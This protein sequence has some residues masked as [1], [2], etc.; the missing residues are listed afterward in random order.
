M[1][2]SQD[3]TPP[4]ADPAI[5]R[6]DII[7]DGFEAEWLAGRRPHFQ[8]F[9]SA[10]AEQDRPN[11]FDELVAMDIEYRRNAGETPTYEDYA[12][13]FP[14]Y[15]VAIRRAIQSPSE[16]MHGHA[17]QETWRGYHAIT[18]LGK[19]TSGAIYRARRGKQLVAIRELAPELVDNNEAFTRFQSELQKV[20]KLHHP[21]LV[22]AIE[23][24][25]DR[26]R[27]FVVSEYV[28]G[29]DFATLV[30]R[31]GLVPAAEACEL[32]SQA[33]TGLGVAH[34][35]GYVHGNLKPDKLI[36]AGQ[37]GE[38]P[39]VKILGLG[40]AS[41]SKRKSAMQADMAQFQFSAPEVR[42]SRESVDTRADIYALGACLQILLYGKAAADNENL[43][44]FDQE[45]IGLT[46]EST[47]QRQVDLPAGLAEIVDR[48]L[49]E[50]P[51]ARIA[52]TQDVVN[53]L[54][55]FAE[56]ADLE[57]LAT[58]ANSP[59]LFGG[60]VKSHTGA[61]SQSSGDEVEPKPMPVE[62]PGYEM[63]ELLGR[64]GM[65]VVFRARQVE[66]DRDVAVKLVLSGQL[67]SEEQRMRLRLEAEAVASLQHP[68]IVQVYDAGDFNSQPFL[69][70]EFVPGESLD[71]HMEKSA[72][73][74]REAAALI[75]TLSRGIH[76]AHLRGIV[77]RDLKPAN[78]LMT[79]A[80]IPK[81]T[82]FG[83]AKRLSDDMSR[84]RSGMLLGTPRY[85]A[86]EQAAGG[87][88]RVGPAADIY[89]LGAILYQLLTRQ[90]VFDAE[91]L[92]ELLEAIKNA[93]PTPLRKLRQDVPRD[94]ETIC[95]KC[96]AKETSHRYES[97]EHLAEDLQRYRTSRPILARHVGTFERTLLWARR[98]PVIAALCSAVL[99]LGL[100]TLIG[101]GWYH[102]QLLRERDRAERR[103]QLASH[104]VGQIMD[105]VGEDRLII[106]PGVEQ[107][108]QELLEK[109]LTIC[110][111]LTEENRTDIAARRR[112]GFAHRRTGDVQRLLGDYQAAEASYGQAIG[113]LSVLV[114]EHPRDDESN[115][116]LAAAHNFAG[117]LYRTTGRGD[118]ARVAYEEARQIQQ[119]LT[120]RSNNADVVAELARTLYNLGLV[121]KNANQ[122]DAAMQRLLNA[123]G[124]LES[125]T[126]APDAPAGH[127]QHLARVNLNRGSVLRLLKR[128]DEAAAAFEEAIREFESLANSRPRFTEYR[129][130]LAVA[131][132][133]HGN[134]LGLKDQTLATSQLGRSREML[135]QLAREYPRVPVYQQ[136]L[137]NACNGLA[138]VLAAQGHL[139]QASTAW[140]EATQSLE[141][142]HTMGKSSSTTHADLGMCLG[143]L[144]RLRLMQGNLAQAESFLERGLAEMG[145][146]LK[147]HPQH[148]SYRRATFNQCG[149]L[150]KV[151]MRQGRFD[152]GLEKAPQL[153]I[154]FEGPL[155][156]RLLRLA[157]LNNCLREIDSDEKLSASQQSA[158]RER[159]A[160]ASLPHLEQALRDDELAEFVQS[161]HRFAKLREIASR[162]NR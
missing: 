38:R 36:L 94:L 44:T 128:S 23:L 89:S 127:R 62:L 5:Q 114:R 122:L 144:G 115:R 21:N 100:L 19:G 18:L 40:F 11:L 2:D 95:L 31:H 158:W 97:A 155:T 103:F 90:P 35:I 59:T 48:M 138:A 126:N 14:E 13:P 92:W 17:A 20:L 96:L 145:P 93:D 16:G 76:A 81:I 28:T 121:E 75:E 12:K 86:P 7:C 80:G 49:Q 98:R 132:N 129:F 123:A 83:L 68:N 159:F 104:A 65:G 162:K 70:M 112:L 109:A 47:Q 73:S 117:E 87:V 33:A 61:S 8:A 45:T 118:E 84:T 91:S 46:P 111:N 124:L 120:A 57:T 141:R 42:D 85:M 71:R 105:E 9:L 136:E 52:T 72:F 30:T 41:L 102:L 25:E 34:E 108:R 150:A 78:I 24:S 88:A 82:D 134:L 110:R 69:V 106:E 37:D 54:A 64:G 99:L 151:L 107:R 139:E 22:R 66:L 74:C 142:L 116:Q 51:T 135:A 130:E 29:V 148:P 119:A 39:I 3:R 131:L 32:I 154:D 157:F 152:Q 149:D 113:I 140:T 146:V 133:N 67:A 125:L 53:A 15:S 27:H 147:S 143:N 137:A 56:Q 153:T 160:E 50:N 161:S 156:S 26:G 4:R 55:P 58:D 6:I 10:A 77:H 60:S 63:K 43:P 79:P 101:G 1:S